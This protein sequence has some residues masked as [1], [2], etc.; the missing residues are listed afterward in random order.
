MEQ[1]NN[2]QLVNDLITAK[3]YLTP[4][5]WSRGPYFSE[6]S[7]TV[8]MCAHGAVQLVINPSCKDSIIIGDIKGAN[9]HA[10]DHSPA[11]RA[12]RG[13]ADNDKPNFHTTWQKQP[14]SIKQIHYLLGAVGLTTMFNDHPSTTLEMVKTK[15]DEAIA[16]AKLLET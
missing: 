8:C 5:T 15:F 13:Y 16:L 1:N 11:E 2:S 3:N 7:G 9:I 12:V 4:E 14:K 10:S 6:K